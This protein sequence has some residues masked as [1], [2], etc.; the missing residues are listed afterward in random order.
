MEKFKKSIPGWLFF[1]CDAGKVE[2]KE[3]TRYVEDLEKYLA[4]GNEIEPQFTVEELAAKEAA[5]A[6]QALESQ[7]RTCENLLDQTQYIVAGDCD[8]DQADIDKY[9]AWRVEIKK[10]MRS[11]ILQEIPEKPK[12]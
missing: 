9:K 7:K 1:I 11:E 6:K 3:G 12:P 10:I 4:E 5:E 2:F 8:F